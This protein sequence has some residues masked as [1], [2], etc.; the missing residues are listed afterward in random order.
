[1]NED[2]VVPKTSEDGNPAMSSYVSYD[3]AGFTPQECAFMNG[4][5]LHGV[6]HPQVLKIVIIIRSDACH[7]CLQWQSSYCTDFSWCIL[8]V[9]RGPVSVVPNNNFVDICSVFCTCILC[10]CW[11]SCR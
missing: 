9:D 7:G 3:V 8:I 2:G 1:M 6:L 11:A 10:V 5:L 4:M